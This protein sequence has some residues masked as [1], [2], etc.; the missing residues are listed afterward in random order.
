[1]GIVV[2][3][4]QLTTEGSAR[5]LAVS[6][7]TSVESPRMVVVIGATVTVVNMGAQARG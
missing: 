2:M 7:A 6:T 1:L 3:L 4:S 5:P